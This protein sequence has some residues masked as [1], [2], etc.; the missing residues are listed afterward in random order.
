MKVSNM[1]SSNGNPVPNQFL[2]NDGHTTYFQSYRSIIAKIDY[3]TP[4]K[5]YLDDCFWD[6]S[7]TTSKYR[8]QFTGLTTAQ[9]KAGIADGS[10]KLV[11]LN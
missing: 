3:T 2:I 9:T 8:N 6:Y 5:I 7:K 1:T 4:M 10:I 11:D